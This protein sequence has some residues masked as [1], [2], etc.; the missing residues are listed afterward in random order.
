MDTAFRTED[1]SHPH[2]WTA[3]GQAHQL[4]RLIPSGHE[5]EARIVSLSNNL[6]LDGRG[7]HEGD[8][9]QMC[10]ETNGPRQRWRLK[11]APGHRAHYLENAATGLVLDRPHDAER[12]TWPVLW[13]EHS[14]VNQHWLLVMPFAAPSGSTA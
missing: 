13:S 6:F 8:H 12:G 2:L 4:W 10:A 14:G 3:H 5:G 7:S 1:G 11:P 9:P